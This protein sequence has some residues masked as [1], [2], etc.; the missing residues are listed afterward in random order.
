MIAGVGAAGGL[1]ESEHRV[2]EAFATGRLVDFGAGNE[3]DD[4]PAGGGG[5]GPHRQVQAEVVAALL[6]GA[7]SPEPGRAGR[8]WLRC[9]SIAGRID[10]QDAEVKHALRLEWCHVG[11]G[12]DLADATCRAIMLIGCQLG[13]VNLLGASITGRLSFSGSQLA[14]ADG[15]ALVADGLIVTGGM[16][17]DKG[18]RA[19]GVAI[20]SNRRDF[21]CSDLEW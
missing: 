14:G 5:W 4:D 21:R 7:V 9:A 11:G 15:P 1:S 6:C 8:V 18:F 3:A 12:A 10:L 16:A 19:D 17:C 13:P 2:W 20:P